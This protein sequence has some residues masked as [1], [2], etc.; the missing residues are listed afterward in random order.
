MALW[1]SFTR[2]HGY[3]RMTQKRGTDFMRI[4]GGRAGKGVPAVA[5]R[6]LDRAAEFMRCRATCQ[7]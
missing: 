4:A 6:T 2:S 5:F 1:F 7:R 3:Q